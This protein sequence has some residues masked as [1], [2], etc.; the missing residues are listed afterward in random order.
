MNK[1][2]NEATPPADKPRERAPHGPGTEV[3]WDGGAGR[4][5]YGNQEE[6]LGPAA[7]PEAEGGTRGDAAGRTLE[8]ME[9]V[10]R[11]P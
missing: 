10:R 5:P 3:N 8:Q 11:K 1:P 9:Q 4:Q 7:A 2:A 6:P